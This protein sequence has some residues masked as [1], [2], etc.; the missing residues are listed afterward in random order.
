MRVSF[1]DMGHRMIMTVIV[2]AIYS[3]EKKQTVV[4]KMILPTNGS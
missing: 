2:T 3:I 1:L 4:V